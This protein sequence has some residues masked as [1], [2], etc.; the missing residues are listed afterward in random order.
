ML[1]CSFGDDAVCD[2]VTHKRLLIALYFT[3]VSSSYSCHR[4]NLVSQLSTK[5]LP[6]YATGTGVVSES[7]KYMIDRDESALARRTAKR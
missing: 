2:V 7:H 1:E 5:D 6:S 3:I 4:Q